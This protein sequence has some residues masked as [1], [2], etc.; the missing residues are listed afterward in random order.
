MLV[1]SDFEP[2]DMTCYLHGLIETSNN[3]PRSD[4]FSESYHR[5]QVGEF[6]MQCNIPV[7]R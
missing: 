6:L 7:A 3:D 4:V 1:V 2:S 5:E